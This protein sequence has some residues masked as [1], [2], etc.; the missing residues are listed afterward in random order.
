[1]TIKEILRLCEQADTTG[2]E[3]TIGEG[4]AIC[5]AAQDSRLEIAL[6]AYNYGFVRGQ[7]ATRE[8][9]GNP[10]TEGIYTPSTNASEHEAS[11]E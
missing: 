11:A 6:L 8:R 5:E 2:Y 10:T 4:Q 1:M 7:E 3:I 9:A